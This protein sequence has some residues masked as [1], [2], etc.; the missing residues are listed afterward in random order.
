M[1]LSKTYYISCYKCQKDDIIIKWIVHF[2][3]HKIIEVRIVI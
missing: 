3:I 1:S 2:V